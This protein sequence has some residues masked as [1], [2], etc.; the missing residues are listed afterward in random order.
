MAA[1]GAGAPRDLHPPGGAHLPQLRP[2]PH[3]AAAPAVQPVPGLQQLPSLHPGPRRGE[4]SFPPS[5]TFTSIARW[6]LPIATPSAEP[7]VFSDATRDLKL[8]V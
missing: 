8:V 2:G 7:R 6:L 4:P 5:V 1:A 3:L